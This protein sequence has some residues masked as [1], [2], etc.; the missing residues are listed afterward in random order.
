MIRRKTAA[1]NLEILP[2]EDSIYIPPVEEKTYL[3]LSRIWTAFVTKMVTISFNEN[4]YCFE[5]SLFEV[6]QNK[7]LKIEAVGSQIEMDKTSKRKVPKDFS[8]FIKK[9]KRSLLSSRA[10]IT[11]NLL[12]EAI[13]RV[14]NGERP[15]ISIIDCRND[16]K[17]HP[18]LKKI[19]PKNMNYAVGTAIFIKG[20]PVGFLWGI[21]Q[22]PLTLMQKN[23]LISRLHSLASGISTIVSLEL[24]RK[25][26][27]FWNVRRTIEKIDLNSVV[28]SMF[29]TKREGQVIPIRSIV[30]R[31]L[32]YRTRYRLDASFLVPTSR[33]F[34]ISLKR[35]LPDKMN[36]SRKTLLMIPGLFCNRTIMDQLAREMS[37]H[38][39]YKVI[40][41]DVRGRSKY[42]LP[43]TSFVEAW[44]IDNLICEDFPTAI[45][46]IRNQYPE[47]KIVV[48]G[49]SMG[50]IIPRFYT[51]AYEQIKKTMK[52]FALP[53]PYQLIAGIVS[54]ASPDYIK[55]MSDTPG[56]KIVQKGVAMVRNNRI[57][58][59][60][61]GP[62]INWVISFSVPVIKP[63]INLKN[64]FIIMNDIHKS[65]R[66]LLY[67]IHHKLITL[68]DFIG[69]D[70]ITPPEMY[71]LMEG[72]F[73]EESTKVFI[74]FIR[75]ELSSKGLYS[76]D[77]SI[78]YT[79]C[80][81][82][83][84]MPIFFIAGTRDALVPIETMIFGYQAALSDK[85]EFR[86]FDQGHLGIIYHP[87]TVREIAK[88][89]HEW[90]MKL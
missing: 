62:F 90:I 39:G 80:L 69:Y 22:D 11:S 68:K 25:T 37:L 73:C 13:I 65:M 55:L 30:G 64:F 51:A 1:I 24:D 50:S 46:W 16:P 29:Y 58:S 21:R 31:S 70:E 66:R 82:K 27:D 57:F 78:N 84:K 53:D 60:F 14:S 67:D 85:K 40:S 32:L 71:L 47:D 52:F 36:R 18:E 28:L 5:H 79:E 33:G 35:F 17:V 54:I 74:Q 77:G 61:I 87:P 8:I 7:Y 4:D 9:S 75:S 43:R 19:L 81:R 20:N 72:I 38:Y 41:L 6:I 48:M 76:F 44:S 88:S 34:S 89:T 45:N 15:K 63:T 56:F 59:T 83:L 86:Q 49:H 42:T 3:F 10:Y 23:L 2:C 12:R 26:D